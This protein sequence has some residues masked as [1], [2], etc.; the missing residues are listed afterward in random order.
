MTY[1]K[2]HTNGSKEK[3]ELSIFFI[4][5]KN[6]NKAKWNRIYQRCLK[7]PH[8]SQRY[9]RPKKVYKEVDTNLKVKNGKKTEKRSDERF[10]IQENKAYSTSFQSLQTENN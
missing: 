3:H 10:L 9:E 2:Y 7:E 5:Y 6:Q 8:I 1:E 4:F